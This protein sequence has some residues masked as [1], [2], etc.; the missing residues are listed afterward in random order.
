[1]I[2]GKKLLSIITPAFNEEKNLSFLYERIKKVFNNLDDNY[3]WIVVDDHSSDSTYQVLEN[4]A[5]SDNRVRGVRLSRNYGSHKAIAAGLHLVTGDCAVVMAADLQDPPETIR[6]LIDKW[7]LGAQIVWAVRSVREGETAIT[8]GFSR[9]YY[10]LMKRV[11]GIENLPSTGADFFLIDRKVIEALKLFKESN[12]S[13]FS[14]LTWMGFKQD[15]ISYVKEARLHG[16]SG[17]TFRK[18]RKLVLDSITSFSH[19]P[20]RIM[21]YIGF[22]IAFFGIIYSLFVINNAL[23]GNPISGWTS[24][25]VVILVIGGF[26]LV[27]LGILGEYV[28][29]TLDESRKRPQYLI[30]EDTIQNSP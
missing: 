15:R 24:L 9:I 6:R 4:I 28:W 1:M 22:L 12:V 18:K 2:S 25:M 17:W 3:E 8:K 23:L 30:Q 27:M 16:K 20:I 5:R 7:E 19:F 14:L 26:Q 29:R 13:I 21:T 10:L 11:V